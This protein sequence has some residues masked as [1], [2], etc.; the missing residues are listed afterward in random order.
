MV[1]L[2]NYTREEIPMVRGVTVKKR[3]GRELA[4]VVVVGDGLMNG[5]KLVGQAKAWLEHHLQH[6]CPRTAGCYEQTWHG[7]SPGLGKI[8]GVVARLHVDPDVQPR[9][10][11]ARLVTYALQLKVEKELNN[12]EEEGVIVP[13]QHWA[14]A[15]VIVPVLNDN[16]VVTICGY[17]NQAE[18]MWDMAK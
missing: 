8:L 3:T 6:T 7:F 17:C 2:R 9:F 18:C 10:L 4:V 13:V 5:R 14:W 12:L 16:G 1:K 11:K 15:P